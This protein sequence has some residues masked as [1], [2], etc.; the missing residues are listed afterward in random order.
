VCEIG[1]KPAPS[2]AFFQEVPGFH[3]PGARQQTYRTCPRRLPR[4][5]CR[6]SP[7]LNQLGRRC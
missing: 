5:L 6:A 3:W 1:R 2:V 7:S 4:G